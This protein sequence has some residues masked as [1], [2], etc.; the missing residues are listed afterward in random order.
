M[1]E[2]SP[3]VNAASAPGTQAEALRFPHDTPGMRRGCSR[4][5][6]RLSELV[7]RSMTHIPHDLQQQ[8]TSGF[9]HQH[10]DTSARTEHIHIALGRARQDQVPR[11]A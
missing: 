6:V 4:A 2:G 9:R 7:Q 8:H 11:I 10:G 3:T 5:V 1:S